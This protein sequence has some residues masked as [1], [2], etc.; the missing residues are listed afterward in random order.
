M[1]AEALYQLRLDDNILAPGPVY[2]NGTEPGVYQ[3]T[4]PGPPQPVNT[5]ARSWRPFAMRNASQFRPG[6]PP[7]LTSVRYARDLNETKE[8]G[9]IGSTARSAHDSETAQFFIEQS[10]FSLN[11]VARDEVATDGRDL[12]SHARLF[13]LLNVAF[14][15]SVTAVF[16]AKY[17]YLLW[18]PVTAIRGA[19]LDDNRRTEADAGWTPF[20]ATPPHP[21]YPAAHGSVTVAGTR[22]LTR[23]FGPHHGFDVSSPNAPGVTRHYVSFN[24]FAEDAGEARI[25]GGMHYRN[26]IEVGQRQGKQVA[27]W[28]LGHLLRPLSDEALDDFVDDVE[29]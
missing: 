9:E 11:R 23:Y 6:P 28:I 26:S 29:D 24:A 10:P 16:D 15:D 4:T 17:T 13:A 21:E 25:F 19:D 3:I 22:V 1:V 7:P 14:A 2:V 12:L 20:L 18:R 27:N 8:F 5:G